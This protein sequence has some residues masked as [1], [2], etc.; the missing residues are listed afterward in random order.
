MRRR[1]LIITLLGGTTTWPLAARAQ[2]SP[3]PVIGFLNGASPSGYTPYVA[4]FLRG[5]KE[6]GYIEGQT[7]RLNTVGRRA[8]TDGFRGWLRILYIVRLL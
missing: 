1:E 4:G 8:S 5:L 7:S 6:T 2:Q 3:I